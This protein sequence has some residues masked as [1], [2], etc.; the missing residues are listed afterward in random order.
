MNEKERQY[1]TQYMP[2]IQEFFLTELLLEGYMS[3]SEII[4]ISKKLGYEVENRCFF[5]TVA[6][7]MNLT[8]E[9]VAEHGASRY[10]LLHSAAQALGKHCG[11]S[12]NPA[13]QMISAVLGREIVLLLSV[14]YGEKHQLETA[15][16]RLR[17]YLCGWSESLETPVRFRTATST[18][19]D[20]DHISWGYEQARE[21]SGFVTMLSLTSPVIFYEDV[22]LN[23]WDVY[24]SKRISQT[25]H[26]EAE[27]LSALERNDFHRLQMLLHQMAEAEFQFGHITIQA[28]TPMLYTLLNKFRMVLDCMWPLAGADAMAVFDTAPRILYRKSVEEIMDQI[29]TIFN[30]FFASQQSPDS[31][32]IPAWALKMDRFITE[33]FTDPDLNVSTISSYFGLNASYAGRSYKAIYGYSVLERINRLRIEMAQQLLERNMLLKDVA[34]AVGYENRHRMNRAFQK[35][36]GHT[37]KEAK[38]G[39]MYL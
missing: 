3:H 2:K 30:C 20:L 32:V 14:P 11:D 17:T 15:S 12:S 24:D 18:A 6:T 35:Y 1:P 38:E 13:F 39:T 27:F 26:W 28:A 25:K 31:T 16:E 9:L 10:T 19:C 21:L 34:V 36:M 29:D 7:P 4:G 5:C 37:P 23:G 8:Q 33:N 22:L